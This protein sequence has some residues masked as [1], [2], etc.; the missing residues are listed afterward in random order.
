MGIK[1]KHP[2]SRQSISV[3]NNMNN[4][5]LVLGHRGYRK[6]FPENTL[7]AFSKAF[8]Y[9][10]DGIEC[11]VQKS[12]D[13]VYFVFHD[14]ELHRMTGFN[15]GIDKE[16]SAELKTLKIGEK[17]SIPDFD[18]FLD[19]LPFD[20]FINIE[21]K[22][23]TLTVKDSQIIIEKLDV[24]KMKDNIL[25]SSFKHELLPPFRM[26]GFK[27]GLL[28]EY[29]TLKNSPLKQIISIFRYRP[30]SVNPPVNIF[31][32]KLPFSIKLF[33][34]AAKLLRIKF[35]FWTVNSE[36][37]YNAVK[38]FAYAVITDDVEGIISLRDRL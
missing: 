10:A 17:D 21:L 13:G 18:S 33:V 24:K 14:V 32:D 31:T 15:S 30:W 4:K 23:E 12:A 27:T 11:D 6:K 8:E 7:L 20:K 3:V 26:T 1:E 34:M 16:M 37:Q 22:E 5:P 9:G 38:N 36:E 28:F 19:S 35:C 29:D 25:I 2:V